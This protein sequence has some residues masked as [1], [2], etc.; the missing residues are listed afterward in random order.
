[1]DEDSQRVSVLVQDYETDS[2]ESKDSSIGITQDSLNVLTC[3][4]TPVEQ[5]GSP[6]PLL[7]TDQP[8]EVFGIPTMVYAIVVDEI[9]KAAWNQARNRISNILAEGSRKNKWYRDQAGQYSLSPAAV[10]ALST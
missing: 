2:Q 10:G 5:T 7:E 4:S 6:S 1:M 9:P 8:D 3:P